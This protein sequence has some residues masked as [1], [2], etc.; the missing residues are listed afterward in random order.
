MDTNLTNWFSRQTVQNMANLACPMCQAPFAAS[1]MFD[2]HP[3]TCNECGTN[4]VEWNVSNYYYVIDAD[5]APA[6]VQVLLS[7]LAP[8]TEYE[9]AH[10]LIALFRFLDV[11][12]PID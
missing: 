4:L 11:K 2:H 5:Q 9:A 12:P 10:E 3:R 1:P 6:I 8:L 7:H